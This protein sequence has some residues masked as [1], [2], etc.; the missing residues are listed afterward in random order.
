[1]GREI[2]R[3]PPDFCHPIDDDGDYVPGAHY[4]ALYG[5]DPSKLTAYQIYENTTEGT[6]V[7]PVFSTEEGLLKWLTD[8]GI[9]PDSAKAFLTQGHAPLLIIQNLR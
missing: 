3:V 1:M 9:S 6:P 2:I 4:E 7:S 5:I 8:R